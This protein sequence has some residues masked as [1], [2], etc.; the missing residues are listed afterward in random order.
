MTD[1]TLDP[2]VVEQIAEEK[3]EQKATEKFQQLQDNFIQ[4]IAGKKPTP[5]PSDWG[6]VARK[7]D[8]EAVKTQTKQ[9][10]LDELKAQRE[11][12]RKADEE[13]QANE[14]KRKE[15]D[16]R[17]RM[18]NEWKEQSAQWREA[19]ED[20]LIPAINPEVSKVLDA[21]QKGTGRAP[22][23]EEMKDPGVKAYA[24]ARAAYQK[25]RK[26][27]SDKPLSFY[28]Y[29]EKFHNKQPAGASAPVLGNTR[30]VQPK[31]GYT[32]EEVHADTRKLNNK[33]AR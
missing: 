8:I 22:T 21:W 9:E 1:Q 5:A 27:N 18:D 29:I 10:I 31:T 4:S 11:A 25:M 19:V 20:G 14:S 32:Y 13:R 3:A 26:E 16:E 30:S 23:D 2:K 7:D 17:S 24:E 33:W 15:E 28:R 6:E 12:E